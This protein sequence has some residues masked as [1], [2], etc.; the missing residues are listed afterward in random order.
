MVFVEQ[1]ITYAWM[2]LCASDIGSSLTAQN[3]TAVRPKTMLA[4]LALLKTCE[5]SV[6]D[7]KGRE[8]RLL[9]PLEN[10]G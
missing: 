8:I 5:T 4:Q 1:E 10:K 7:P 6:Q 9:C 2:F 3:I